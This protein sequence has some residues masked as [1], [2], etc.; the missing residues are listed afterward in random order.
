MQVA[1]T[2]HI[3]HS[4]RDT[5]SG[6][7]NAI[8]TVSDLGA[9]ERHNNHDYSEQDVAKMQSNINLAL[10]HLNKHYQLSSDGQLVEVEGQLDL[11]G[12]VRKIYEKE[13]HEAIE[14]Y[15]AEQIKKGHPERQITSYIDKIS[16]DKQQEVAVE[17]LLQI[18][19][20]DDWENKTI[21]D[22]R[23]VAPILIEMLKATLAELDKNENGKFVLAGAS[24]HLNEGTPHIHYVGVPVQE[25]PE[26]KRGLEKRVKKTAVFTKDTL[27]TGLQDNVR[28]K[29]EPMIEDLFDWT[30]IE[31]KTGRNEDRDKNTQ[32]NEILKEQIHENQEVLAQIQRETEEANAELKKTK[33]ELVATA[34]TNQRLQALNASNLKIIEKNDEIIAEQQQ[35]FEENEATLAEQADLIGM[36]Q[37]HEEYLEGGQKAHK[38]MD[39]IQEDLDELPKQ[40]KLFHTKEAE[41]WRQR[42]IRRLHDMMEFVKYTIGKLQIFEKQYPEEATEQLSVPAQKRASALDN[43]I[44]SA[45]RQR[46]FADDDSG[47]RRKRKEGYDG[48]SSDDR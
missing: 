32:V 23:A 30:F 9:T 27:G 43:V 3:G 11:E 12:N 5:H 25:S 29:V 13:F 41:S 33:A 34:Q 48:Q 4:S 47:F 15:N 38:A 36:Y 46:S 31:K 18:G 42:T 20:L 22:R 39:D 17:G 45:E 28:A 21:E 2:N 16:E 35:I 37:S 24:L 19:S 40:A 7:S 26:S 8:S 1:Y 6:K 14:K 44:A 10:R